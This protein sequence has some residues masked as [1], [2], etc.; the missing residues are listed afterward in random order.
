MV[1][2]TQRLFVGGINHVAVFQLIVLGNVC[3]YERELPLNNKLACDNVI[4]LKADINNLYYIQA[5]G[6]IG[7]FEA[8]NI[9]GQYIPLPP[10]TEN[11]Y[12][13]YN[14]FLY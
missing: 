7:A 3:N 4:Y 8:I 1:Y 5:G 9:P 6:A 10:Y 13:I 14:N 2:D 12:K 11:V